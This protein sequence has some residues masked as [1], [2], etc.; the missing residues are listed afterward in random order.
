MRKAEILCLCVCLTMAALTGCG[1]IETW[2][3]DKMLEEAGILEEDSYVNYQNR[4]EAGNVDAKGYYR[5]INEEQE[6]GQV[7]VTFAVNSNLD[8]QYYRDRDCTIP[9]NNESCYLNPGDAVYGK[10]AVSDTVISGAYEFSAFQI[11][12]YSADS[13]PRNNSGM[14]RKLSTLLKSDYQEDGIVLQIPE[15]YTGTEI[16]VEPIGEYRQIELSLKDYYTDEDGNFCEMPGTWFID[17]MEY[18]DE[19]VEVSPLSSHVIS[20]E[21]DSEQYFYVGSEPECYYCNQEEGLV[22]FRG[23]ETSDTE[24]VYSVELCRYLNVALLSGMERTVKINGGEEKRIEANTELE[25]PHLKYG[26]KVTIET[27]KTWTDLEKCRELILTN[28]TQNTKFNPDRQEPEQSYQYTMIVPEKDDQFVFDPSEYSYEHGT[29]TFRCFGAVVSGTQYLARGSKIYYEQNT[30]DDGYWLSG[31]EHYIVVGEEEETRR[32]LEEIHFTRKAQVSLHLNQPEY[33]GQILYYIDGR[34]VT[35]E[36]ITTYSGTI[37]EM[38]FEAWEGWICNAT[39]GA[40]YEVEEQDK[41]EIRIKGTDMKEVFTEDADH[42]PE[43]TIVLEESVKG[44]MQ[45]EVEASGLDKNTY[46]YEKH[47]FKSDCT[48]IDEQVIGTQEPV[49]MQIRNKSIPSGKAVKIVIQKEVEEGKENPVPEIRYIEDLTD[50]QEPIYIYEPS[51][52]ADSKVWYKSIHITV[53]L[54]EGESFTM[55]EAGPNTTITV[56]REA[57]GKTLQ[58]GDFVEESQKLTVTVFPMEGYYIAEGNAL[59]KTAFQKELDYEKYRTQIDKLIGEHEAKSWIEVTLDRSDSRA[60]YIYKC[61]GKD[62]G[63]EK[64]RLREGQKLTLEYEITD[65]GYRLK[66]PAGGFL[67][68]GKSDKK[69][70][71]SITITAEYDGRVLTESDFGIEIVEV[72][73]GE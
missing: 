30:A 69:A 67:G 13:D 52:I 59:D 17:D 34:K 51:Q 61:D 60:E 35:E 57:D 47:R 16:S 19:R 8:I 64:L 14:V 38:K 22:V 54:V 40:T 24:T 44:G 27:D 46:S 23:R 4:A 72:T 45:F 39:N 26:D 49:T 25:I 65:S 55:P 1:S 66:E 10:V 2:L 68:I 6:K 29:I 18:T 9:M 36:N 70:T 3:E 21:Y 56:R 15:D 42:K 7:H 71:E 43:L 53:S 12:E 20:Y 31:K 62:V 48:I 5:E 41:Q 73:E 28:T 37:V 11:Y 58:T 33:G 63:E 32:Q 50:V